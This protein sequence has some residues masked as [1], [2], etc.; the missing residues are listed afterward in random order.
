MF[1]KLALKT[2]VLIALITLVIFLLTLPSI[3]KIPFAKEE[4]ANFWQI[5]GVDD[6]KYSRDLAR[7]K[8]NDKS[9]D[10]TIEDHVKKIAET[11][12]THIALGTP[13]DAEFIPFLKRWV[14]SARKYGLKIWFRGNFS[15][16]EGWFS[17]P[18]ID[19]TKH[20]QQ[21][22]DFILNNSQL[23]LDGDIFSSCPE[24]ENGGPGDPRRIRDAE[25]HRLFLINE[26]QTVNEAFKKINK[27]LE[28]RLNSTNKDV[29]DLIFDK[30]TAQALGNVI[31]IDH[32][33]P[34]GK[35]L[36]NDIKKL[37]SKTGAQ[38]VVGEFGAPIPDIHGPMTDKNQ[39]E[40]LNNTLEDLSKL[41]IVIGVNYWVGFGGSTQIWDD[42]GNA[43]PA[44][45]SLKKFYT[46][47]EATGRMVDETERGI[48]K[49]N[50]T[51]ADRSYETDSN[52][53]FKLPFVGE[54]VRLTVIK[55]GYK[56]EDIGVSKDNSKSIKIIIKPEN[57]SLLYKFFK[58]INS[59]KKLLKLPF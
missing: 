6:M 40:W 4:K 20:T 59:V 44:V 30:K 21:T 43:R 58:L 15:G 41:E 1:P 17:Y 51:V 50:V 12:A 5:Q 35:I 34:N 2:V 9:F 11:G 33:T 32:Y 37:Y 55:Q 48:G 18:K 46:P 8:L 22:R 24:C 38:I 56:L 7:E 47:N 42:N 14:N 26:Y 19:R 52:G 3:D 27:K 45:I 25:G 39:A 16:W 13:Y 57:E 28:T 23:F 54:E 49:A 31:S 53:N 36:A 10:K 29:A